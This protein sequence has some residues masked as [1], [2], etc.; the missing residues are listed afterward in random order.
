MK[1]PCRTASTNT[2]EQPGVTCGFDEA[3]NGCSIYLNPMPKGYRSQ[4]SKKLVR[5]KRLAILL[6]FSILTPIQ[7]FGQTVSLVL[8][9]GG[10]KGCAHI[11]V[12]KAL[13]ENGIPI[14]N[15]SG[16]SIG[17]IVGGLY[18]MG[19]SPDEMV[20]IFKSRDFYNW[21][22]GLI[23]ESY[24]FNINDLS[25]T[26]AENLSVGFT[27]DRGGLKTK[28]TSSI[29]PP[30]G[31]DI[32]FEEMFAQG[33]AIS[34]GNFDKLFV[35]FRCNASD[36]VN[37]KQVYFRE[38][39]L[40]KAIR[41]S[42]TFPLYFTPVYID[43]LLLFDGGIYNNFLWKEA[44]QEFHPNIIVGS[45][46]ASNSKLPSDEDPLLQVEAMI[47][48]ITDYSIPDSLGIVIDTRLENI[49]LLDFDK[50]DEIVS[51]GYN[52]TLKVIPKLRE[53][54]TRNVTPEELAMR[55]KN[56][57]QNLPPLFIDNIRVGNLSDRQK[58]YL[59]KVIFNEYSIVTF[60]KFKKDY[61]RLVSD[62]TF[63]RLIPEFEFDYTS[64][65]FDVALN[66]T[67][68]RSVDL[69]LGL[70]LSSDVGNEGFASASYKWLSRTSNTIYG[71]IYFGKLLSS[72]RLDYIKTFPTK[73]P[74]SLV[75][76]TI[77]SR[78]DYHSSNPIPFFEDVKPPYVLQD[79]TFA[80]V[81]LKVSNTSATTTTLSVSG[82][83]KVDHYYQAMDY[84]SFDVPDQTTFKF[85]KGSLCFDKYTL[86]S[87]QYATRGRHQQLVISG[88]SGREEHYPGTTA[89]QMT[90]VRKN[91]SFA[92]FYLYNESYHRIWRRRFWL[93]LLFES[94]YSTQ[95]L[96]SNYF[97]SILTSNQ[98]SPTPHSNLIFIENY[99]STQYAAVGVAPIFDFLINVH[100]R[101]GAYL[102]QPFRT[103]KQDDVGVANYSD[104]FAKRWLIGSASLVYRTPVGPIALTLGYYPTA[105][106]NGDDIFFN[107]T[108][109]YSIFNS[110]VFDN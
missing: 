40:G 108:F 107:L 21:S 17:A 75:A 34:R 56:F 82:G 33:T 10:A 14:D 25:T 65:L 103:L 81:S 69:G 93:E 87:K 9:G 106:S 99:R 57:R 85:F 71:N 48:G 70:S 50:V 45:K 2:Y 43:S 8:S 54:I 100:F 59:H 89:P 3:K 104:Y 35:P 79:E 94:Y 83:E 102:Y 46:V 86:D 24:K 20:N 41:T 90:G 110:R 76:C 30:V 32:A 11:G 80:T 49:E 63:K 19:Y 36:V 16:T 53:Q 95:G 60:D 101:V 5:M 47:V 51:A 105:N 67:L 98:F 91:H 26:D 42:M 68:N 77:A 92:T 73:I 29:V 27:F 4:K 18:A 39:N 7:N 12:I 31:L 13:E 72:I 1:H 22:N 44:L 55:R 37:K 38:G 64:G 6:L 78:Y 58:T 88:F 84:Y 62:R 28:L 66:P 23:D 52:E 15:V 97:A 74:V 109:G 61:Y 96:F